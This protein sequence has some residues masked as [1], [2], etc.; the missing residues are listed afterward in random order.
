MAEAETKEAHTPGFD[1]FECRD[2]GFDS[3]QRDDFMGSSYC[4]ICAGDC[5]HSVL[6]SRR[7]ATAEDRPEGFDARKGTRAEQDARAAI[8][9]A[10]A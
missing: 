4:P 6:M 5:G 8:Q 2:C 9:R 10:E 3:V 7:P 1:H